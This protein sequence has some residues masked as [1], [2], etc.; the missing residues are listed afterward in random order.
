[1]S[2]L[3]KYNQK[4]KKLEAINKKLKISD[5]LPGLKHSEKRTRRRKS[6]LLKQLMIDIIR[7]IHSLKRTSEHIKLQVAGSPGGSVV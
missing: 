7:E 4:Y 6:S 5:S 1:M 3:R 2:H